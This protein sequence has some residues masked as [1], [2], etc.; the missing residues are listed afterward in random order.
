MQGGR[1]LQPLTPLLPVLCL[2][3][4]MQFGQNPTSSLLNFGCHITTFY[5]SI[6][7]VT[8]MKARGRM[9]QKANAFLL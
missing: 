3:P 9:M 7:S 5:Y 1:E 6:K 4:Y 8:M 2:H